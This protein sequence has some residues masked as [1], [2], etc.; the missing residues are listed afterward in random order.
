LDPGC[1]NPELIVGKEKESVAKLF[2]AS[3][4]LTHRKLREYVCSRCADAVGKN[5]L[6]SASSTLF[7]VS[8]VFRL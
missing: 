2:A 5:R 6:G 1:S 7:E 4:L 8:A 3:G